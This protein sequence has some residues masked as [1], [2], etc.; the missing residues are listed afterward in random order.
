[1]NFSQQKNNLQSW[2]KNSSTIDQ[3]SSC[4]WQK[5][6]LFYIEQGQNGVKEGNTISW[7]NNA[8][9]SRNGQRLAV[10]KGI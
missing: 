5:L 3:P 2:K 9:L 6:G 7:E 4:I 8:E 10:T 1:M